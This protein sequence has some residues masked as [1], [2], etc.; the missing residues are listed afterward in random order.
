MRW[1]YSTRSILLCILLTI[2]IS[3][4]VNAQSRIK[5]TVFQGFWWDYWNNNF[6][7]GWANY[8]TEMAPRLKAAG[9]D[10][11]WIP[12]VYK[13]AST[14]Y[15][16]YGPFDMYDLGDKYQ[17]G[18]GDSLNVRGRIGS[19]DELLR[20]IAVMHANGIEVIQDIVLNHNDGAGSNNG[21]GGQDPESSFS[22]RSNSGYKNFR[23]TSYATPLLDDSQNDYWSRSGR[24]SKNYSNFHPTLSHDCLSGNDICEAFFGPDICYLNGAYGQS[25][26]IPTSG[27]VTINGATRPFYNPAQS[28]NYMR[29]KGRDWI[30]WFKKQTGSDG[31]RWDAVKH[32][33]TVVQ[34]DYIYNT[35]YTLPTWAAGNQNMF[36]VGEWIGNASELD[37]YV[38]NVKTSSAPNGVSNEKHT[39]T[40]D[41][42]M[43]GYGPNGGLYSMVLAGGSYNMQN[44]PGEQQGERYMVYPDGHRVYRT[45]PFVN[46]HDTYRPKLDANGNFLQPLGNSSG[47]NTSDEVGGN[48][49]HIDPRE[50]RLAAA[51]ATACAVDGNPV[52]FLE[53]IFDIGTTGKRY[54]HLPSNTTDLPI[55]GD[56]QNILQ[57]HQKL[58]FKDG[59][60]AVPSALTG[61]NAP[62]IVAGSNGLPDHIVIER[63]G[64][65][66]IGISDK[67]N[68]AS[69]NSADEQMYVTADASWIGKQLYDY[70]GAHGVTTS[71][72]F[73]DRRVLIRTAP[74]GHTISGANGHGYSIWAPAPAG[75][76]IT[77]VQDLYNYIGTYTQPRATETTQEWEMADDLGDSHCK[78]LG[79][80]GAL[81][82]NSSN[83]RVAGKI[84]TDA[85][86]TINYKVY[87]EVDGR[88]L[89]LSLWDLDGNK[90]SEAQGI[91]PSA[92]PVTGSYVAANAGWVIIKVRNTT[93][94]QAGQ[95]CFVN[96]SYTA[97][98]TVDTRATNN[99]PETRVAIWTGNKGTADAFDCSNWEE[100]KLPSASTNVIVTSYASPM[101]VI[102][103]V[104]SVKN[105]TVETGASVTIDNTTLKIAGAISNA[106]T[107][108]ATT[109][110]IEMN[111]T[112][113]QT[114]PANAFSSNT[115]KTLTIN[116]AAGVTIGGSL[117]ITG[118]LVSNAG[119]LH[120]GGF[121]TLKSTSIANTAI[122]AE[123]KGSIDGDVTVE[124]FIPL[125]KRAYRQ[126]ASGVNSTSNIH[127]NWQNGGV[128][129]QGA[130]I[131]I[132]GSASGANGFD[133]TQTGS[134][135]MFTYTP[136]AAGFTAVPNTDVNTLNALKGYRT[137]IIGDRNADL[138]IAN[139]TGTG[140]DNIP[141]NAATTL[142][143]T[144]T[145]ITG[146]V[147]F[148]KTG[149]TANGST[150]ATIT[151][152]ATES[153]FSFIANPYWSPVNFDAL[154]KTDI[155][156]TY[157]IWDPS[158]GHRGAYTSYTTG[159]GSSGGAMTKDIQPGQS[160]FVQT[161]PSAPAHT[162]ILVLENKYYGDVVGNPAAPYINALIANPKTA[163]LTQS[164][165][166]TRPSQPNYLM[167]FSGSQQG[168]TSNTTPTNLP[169]TTPNLGASLISS[170]KTFTGYSEDLP[171]VGYTGEVSGAYV[172]K[173]NPWVNWQGSGANTLPTS[174][175]RPFTDFP[176]DYNS[177]PTVSIV[178][179]N[180][181]NDMHDGTV[182]QADTWIQNNLGPYI[183][184]CINNNSLFIL[185]FDEDNNNGLNNNHILTTFTGANIT[186]GSYSQRI[187]H[188]NVLRTLE[189]VYQLPYAGNSGDSS[190]IQGIWSNTGGAQL[191]PSITFNENNKTSVLTNTFR[192]DSSLPS[193]LSIQLMSKPPVAASPQIADAATAA[194]KENFN[195]A[196]GREDAEKFTNPDEN[197]AIIRNSKT[198]GLEGRPL[199]TA[200]DTI[201]L[202][203][204]NLYSNNQYSLQLD[205]SNFDAG[206]TAFL[207]DNYL[208]QLHP[209][210]TSGTTTYPFTFTSSDTASFYHR[211]QVVF[212]TAVVLPVNFTS[213]KAYKKQEGI[214]VEWS[215]S[216]EINIT[217]YEVEKSADGR[218]FSLVGTRN[219]LANGGAYANYE[220][221]D[222]KPFSGTNYYR[223]KAIGRNNDV[224]YTNVVK[225]NIGNSKSVVVYPNP[226]KDNIVTVQLN[227]LPKGK[228]DLVISNAIGQQVYKKT[229]QHNGGFASHPLHL[230]LAKGVYQL[231][232]KGNDKR[233]VEQLVIE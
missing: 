228:Y 172:R 164:Y 84:Y 136:G 59:D 40:F 35:K 119:A 180:Q 112:T 141:L 65:A 104:M 93:N 62:F 210:S 170:G 217:R 153:N 184:W 162:V 124:R 161:S 227:N 160:I 173:H 198:V 134:P 1:I 211:F 123:V 20:M 90:L 125:S 201:P 37:A 95:K 214:Q 6:P 148:A 193:R 176:T 202:R 9:F 144:G 191:N 190:A 151:L 49:Q 131:H 86:K 183:N 13:N 94:T 30:Q 223:V 96:V 105:I 185:T 197:I 114:I 43:R 121:V 229:V 76:T 230:N 171:S 225:V 108:T 3:V 29:D 213:I 133:A 81:P 80:G 97:P 181:D 135:S 14:S 220:W 36:C 166:M 204:W 150:D 219:A 41:F 107:I 48:G 33:E 113:A 51:Y 78:S 56:L 53:D 122:V 154:T 46:S 149:T 189:D 11:I 199:I 178:V 110:N 130:G 143:A 224:Q 233:Y 79:Q 63:I 109:A 52:F 4:H 38:N 26:N 101:P 209:L 218:T 188:Y 155:N 71:E 212:K 69:D 182:A 75:V 25:S 232:V 77:S 74:V 168:V 147:T 32:F 44:L 215:I 106:G 55:R 126:L 2:F 28:T 18:G 12:P 50:P 177:L 22:T 142:K 156:P 139:N 132:T 103:S 206:I 61:G 179:P 169:F 111:G 17:K 165:G 92:A 158:I 221:L 5:R 167:L 137:F 34:E 175:N 27:S 82:T 47:W 115:I 66:I 72:V 226:S 120:T 216:N 24:W 127:S 140:T 152:G 174:V 58:A 146:P 64:K 222:E 138:T 23:F 10:A 145:L 196:L 99:N 186:G 187:T 57:A 67:Y 102:N 83:Q 207:Q 54:S 116:N 98:A 208:N 195:A 45:V 231:Q 88:S 31:W 118:S 19:K 8:L 42:S 200:N 194:F 15:V 205:A 89:S 7:N 100:G 157:W 85:G 68:T 91:A 21:S 87:P 60:Y 117:N 16:G 128:Y 192:Q 203:L 159:S 73:G 70:S 163:T 129:A 39:G